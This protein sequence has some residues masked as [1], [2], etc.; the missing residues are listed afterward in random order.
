M[1]AIAGANASHG[2]SDDVFGFFLRNGLPSGVPLS[3]IPPQLVRYFQFPLMRDGDR[4]KRT[5]AYRFVFL[6]TA[7]EKRFDCG[8]LV[9]REIFGIA[10]HAI[11]PDY[12]MTDCIPKIRRC[13]DASRPA[14]FDRGAQAAH[15]QSLRVPGLLR[16]GKFAG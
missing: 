1:R 7:P 12:I 9:G 16:S 13:P 4:L 11:E 3:K 15:N 8:L 6:N 14:G 10:D 2:L 5:D